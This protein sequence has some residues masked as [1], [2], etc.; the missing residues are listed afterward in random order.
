MAAAAQAAH[1]LLM[2]GFVRRFGNDAAAIQPMLERGELGDIYF[3]KAQY[4][5]RKGYPGGW[6]GDLAY[7]GGGPLIDLGVHVIDLV[8]YLCG[9]R[10]V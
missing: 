2:V 9:N 1:R 5:R 10:C 7:A 3:A 4:L 8:K 6:F